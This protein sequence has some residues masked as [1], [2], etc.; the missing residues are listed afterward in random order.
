MIM[1]FDMR[2]YLA[3]DAF[4]QEA[5][6][7]VHANSTGKIYLV[8]SYIYKKITNGVNASVKD[9]DFVVDELITDIVLPEDW[10]LQKNIFGHPR[11]VKSQKKI[12]P[13]Q[14]TK[15]I[16]I[17]RKGLAPTLENYLKAIPLNVQSIAYDIDEDRLIGEVGFDAIKKRTVKLNNPEHARYCCKYF[18]AFS[19]NDMIIRV[20]NSLE[21]NYG[22]DIEESNG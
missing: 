21:F 16:Y 20:A 14:L 22:L 9:I 2:Q 19:I 17:I 3:N 1:N 18:H 8:G 5:F 11:F 10:K 13:I 12:D 7:I 4:Y 15:H 6:P